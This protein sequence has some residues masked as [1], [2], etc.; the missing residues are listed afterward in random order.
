MVV[1][2]NYALNNRCEPNNEVLH[3]SSYHSFIRCKRER[4][5]QG[6]VA[7]GNTR[8]RA[9]LGKCSMWLATSCTSI[10]GLP[11]LVSGLFL[12]VL[13]WELIVS[14]YAVSVIKDARWWATCRESTT[15]P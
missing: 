9:Q 6:D 3:I 14:Y 7:Q 1:A 2:E 15:L 8:S 13:M 12:S 5:R 11:A 10:F 4:E